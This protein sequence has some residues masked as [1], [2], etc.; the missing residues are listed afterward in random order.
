MLTKLTTSNLKQKNKPT[1]DVNIV[2]NGNPITALHKIKFLCIYIQDSTNWNHHI[3][4]I[5]PKLSSACYAMRSIKTVMSLS[6]LKTIYYSSFKAVTSYGLPFW[7]NSPHTIKVFRLQK[8]IIRT[9]LGYKQRV[10][11]RELFR[12][13]NILPLATQYI[14]LLMIFVVQ[15]RNLFTLNSDHYE[16]SAR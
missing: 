14:L 11:C 16:I 10:S 15:N 5:I 7:G 3:D 13:L 2:C 8:R 12:R 9:I 6:T 4:Y 1:C